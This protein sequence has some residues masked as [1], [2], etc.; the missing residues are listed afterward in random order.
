VYSLDA[1]LALRNM[2]EQPKEHLTGAIDFK[3]FVTS[4]ISKLKTHC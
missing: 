2:V 1:L 4:I 3:I